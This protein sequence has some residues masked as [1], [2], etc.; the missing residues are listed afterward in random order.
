MRAFFVRLL[1]LCESSAAGLWPGIPKPLFKWPELFS[2]L[3]STKGKK[4]SV[5]KGPLRPSCRRW[6]Q[7]HHFLS[8]DF[9][10]LLVSVPFHLII[11]TTISSVFISDMELTVGR[12]SCYQ[13]CREGMNSAIWNHG[14]L[15]LTELWAYTRRCAKCFTNRLMVVL[16]RQCDSESQQGSLRCR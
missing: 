13:H 6:P 4:S 12:T 16:K 3:M 2:T 8:R 14:A 11:I 1:W 10:H 7:R 9:G 15:S 5:W